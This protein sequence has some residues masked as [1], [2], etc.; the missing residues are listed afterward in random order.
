MK[1]HL[2][3]LVFASVFLLGAQAST[4]Q[5]QSEIDALK[6]DIDLFAGVLEE[7]LDLNQNTGLFGLSL[8]GVDPLY[9]QGV[10]LVVEVRSQLATRRN[11]LNL[12]SL[13]S[14]M[15][16][17]RS[18]ENPFDAFRRRSADA[19]AA[20]INPPAVVPSSAVPADS[21]YQD[22]M[23]SVAGVDYT[24]AINTAIEQAANSLRSLRSLGDLD[25]VGHQQMRA[26]LDGL[27]A[28]M[29]EALVAVQ[30]LQQEL[31]SREGN[32]S[33]A[34]QSEMSSRL[35]DLLAEFEPLRD[36]AL[37]KARELQTRMTVA[38]ADYAE[39]WRADIAEF[40]QRLYTALCDFAA[41]LRSLPEQ[42]TIAVV[43]QG[44]GEETNNQ[45]SDKLHVIP[46]ASVRACQQG[47]LNAEQLRAAA[48]EYSY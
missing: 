12:A 35:D 7:A 26:E 41:P 46:L 18:G 42:E 15:Q 36:E 17:L 9:V 37:A 14:T 45:A 28:R 29:A 39:R 47:S 3:R 8:G 21:F 22:M 43:L 27:R 25:E 33:E 4:A 24:L 38:E 20:R 5:Q 30:E 2:A 16:S 1:F 13:N 6:E 31:L 40:E 19:R 10:G 32:E 23:Q 44:L 48:T 11:R 34:E